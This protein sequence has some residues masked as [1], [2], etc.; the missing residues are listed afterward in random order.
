MNYID[1]IKSREFSNAFEAIIPEDLSFPISTLKNAIFDYLSEDDGFF[2]EGFIA[3]MFEFLEQFNFG[4]FE[5]RLERYTAS[6]TEVLGGDN[7][8]T[9]FDFAIFID[10]DFIT[11]GEVT[12][13]IIRTLVD[14][15]NAKSFDLQRIYKLNS[16]AAQIVWLD[17]TFHSLLQFE[18]F[19]KVQE[20]A[21]KP[22]VAINEYSKRLM[23]DVWE[24]HPYI[25][26]RLAAQLSITY[27]EKILS[28]KNEFGCLQFEQVGL[29]DVFAK[30][31]KSEAFR[32][33]GI[34]FEL[35]KE[36]QYDRK[37]GD[38]NWTSKTDKYAITYF[39]PTE[40]FDSS[41]SRADLHVPSVR[42]KVSAIE[43]ALERF[44]NTL[45]IPKGIDGKLALAKLK[46]EYF[47]DY[48]KKT[49]IF[50]LEKGHILCKDKGCPCHKKRKAQS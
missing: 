45:D 16:M 43:K 38:G 36:S 9:D 28:D 4:E 50:T 26:N 10:N 48:D 1:F 31:P 29:Y 39:K 13:F 7:Q 12:F 47:V 22:K 15:A 37:F 35:R 33:R 41:L 21:R 49:K 3:D 32:Y 25:S 11:G 20:K 18:Y 5:L 19:Q 17:A 40:V 42:L 46:Q 2:D 14:M 8:I 6:V 44:K 27:A 24:K 30:Y 23:A 34:E